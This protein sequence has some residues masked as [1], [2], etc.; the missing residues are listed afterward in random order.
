MLPYTEI[1]E[2]NISSFHFHGDLS[3]FPLTSIIAVP[4]DVKSETILIGRYR[5][6]ASEQQL[7][8][9]KEVIDELMRLVFQVKRFFDANAVLIAFSTIL[10]LLLIVVL[11]TRLRQ[12]EMQTMFK[13]GASRNT[14]LLLQL[15]ELLIIFLVGA[16]L[17]AAASW[18]VSTRAT[19]IVRLLL[20]N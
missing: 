5:G 3:D 16:L 7:V 8:V 20:L 13:M 2:K 4:P 18:C 14:M 10:L 15:G 1:N 12:R 17:V 6:N 9:P 19:E 11:S